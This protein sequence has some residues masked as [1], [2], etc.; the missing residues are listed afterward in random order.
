MVRLRGESRAVNR[1][2]AIRGPSRFVSDPHLLIAV[3]G[4]P[5]DELLDAARPGANLT[6]MVSSLLGWFHDE[7]DAAVPWQR[8][9]PEI[10]CTGYAP[11]LICPDD[12]DFD[13]CVVMAEVVA[14]RDVIRWDRLG[15]DASR[16][17]AVGSCV[18]WV[19]GLGAYRFDR[20]EYEAVLAAF[21]SQAAELRLRTGPRRLGDVHPPVT[22][23]RRGR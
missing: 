22:S 5:L 6:G 13:C 10:G 17:G 1:I 14:E 8:V 16:G 12:L 3:D 18:Q 7:A 21:R 4:V 9:L 20:A 19:V 15:F 2:A 11:V 23:C